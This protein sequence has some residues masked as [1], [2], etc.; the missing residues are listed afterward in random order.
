[1]VGI[2]ATMPNMET[3]TT[4]LSNVMSQVKLR[5]VQLTRLKLKNKNLEDMTLK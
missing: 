3:D 5:D 4:S 1:M 2:P